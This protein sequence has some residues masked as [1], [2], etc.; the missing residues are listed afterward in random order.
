MRVDILKK[1]QK[2]TRLWQRRRRS[3]FCPTRDM[4]TRIQHNGGWPLAHDL[5]V[6]F[7]HWFDDKLN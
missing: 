4:W 5:T 6:M 7:V 3:I 1:I 2:V